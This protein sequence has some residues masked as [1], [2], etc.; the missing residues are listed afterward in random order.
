MSKLNN[1]AALLVPLSAATEDALFDVVSRLLNYLEQHPDKDL[2]EVAFTCQTGRVHHQFR[3]TFIVTHR[4]ELLAQCRSFIQPDAIGIDVTQ[5]N[6]SLVVKA[7]KVAFLFPGQGSQYV[8]MG[9]QLYHSSLVFRNAIDRCAAVLDTILPTPLNGILFDMS[10]P[11]R[12]NET[13]IT[14]PALF[15]LEY[16]LA[17]QWMAWGFRPDVVLG[18]SL[19]EWVA[20][21]IGGAYSVED[22]CHLVFQRGALMQSQ[23]QT[24]G[25]ASISAAADKVNPLLSSFDVVIT[26]YNG[27]ENIVI[28]G[29]VQQIDA[30]LAELEAL[31]VRCRP[32]KVSHA[33]HSPLMEPMLDAFFE[34]VNAVVCSTM[35]IPL[36]SNL[37]G[38]ERRELDAHYWSQQ[39]R[40]PVNFAACLEKLQ[41]LQINVVIEIGPHPTFSRLIEGDAEQPPLVLNS[42]RRD[43]DD[44]QSLYQTLG[45]AWSGGVELSWQ[46]FYDQPLPKRLHLPSYPYQRKYLAIGEHP[47]VETLRVAPK[48]KAVLS[49]ES[50]L[51]AVEKV[52]VT[53]WEEIL[54]TTNIAVDS[55]FEQLGADSLIA[56]K[57]LAR[58]KSVT[59]LKLTLAEMYQQKKLGNIAKLMH[60][61]LANSEIEEQ[62]ESEPNYEKA[63]EQL[64]Q[65]AM[66]SAPLELVPRRDVKHVLLLAAHGFLAA[67]V[68]NELYTTT[69]ALISCII[70]AADR[71]DFEAS[72]RNNFGHDL[73]SRIKVFTA[74]SLLPSSEVAIDTIFDVSRVDITAHSNEMLNWSLDYVM[75]HT[76]VQLHYVDP[77]M[78][79]PTMDLIEQ[80][81]NNGAQVHLYRTGNLIGHSVSGKMN[82]N[83]AAN[84]FYK[85][86][87]LIIESGITTEAGPVMDITPVDFIAAALIELAQ[88]QY[89]NNP[90]WH[91]YNPNGLDNETLNDAIR[92]LGYSVVSVPQ[93][94]QRFY[95]ELTSCHESKQAI[96]SAGVYCPLPDRDLL[97]RLLQSGINN[98]VF[99]PPPRW[100]LRRQIKQ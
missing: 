81:K 63:V 32:L 46:S 20:A 55:D 1:P 84:P 29:P 72:L 37:D 15:A 8:G 76:E 88:R 60:Q 61:R 41:Q 85:K 95:S 54:C 53:I 9:K 74:L 64:P 26:A 69:T 92:S 11:G 3:V 5:V 87:Q 86:V 18:H 43:K 47:I 17:Q 16:A 33:F 97:I 94:Y 56:A 79:L 77:L 89:T 70:N 58:T 27:P 59:G 51:V 28:G 100:E 67:H 7:P 39:I 22:A 2:S 48:R 23:C 4:D 10:E 57:L 52:L 75:T 96:E 50:D 73:S 14:Q 80:A 42:L 45:Q 38:K 12:I 44:I 19:G 78:A 34:Q 71:N 13:A 91:I 93:E 99:T 35:A 24:G 6:G 40:Q 21:C 25:M 30:C 82:E 83:I 36:I 65:A 62:Q 98:N 66:I 31:D 90:Q 68:L 49:R